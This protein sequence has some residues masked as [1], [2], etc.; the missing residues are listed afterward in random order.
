MPKIFQRSYAAFQDIV[1]ERGNQLRKLAYN[2]LKQLDEPT[3]YFKVESRPARVSIIVLSLSGDELIVVVQGFLKV[4]FVPLISKVAL[5]GFH[6]FSDGSMAPLT[7]E[8][9]WRFD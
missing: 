8:E 3:E 5:D 6:K 7:R 9:T 2:Q 4:R 1:K